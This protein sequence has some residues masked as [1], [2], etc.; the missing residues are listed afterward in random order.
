MSR[1]RF[2]G[3]MG[4][5]LVIPRVLEASAGRSSVWT[6]QAPPSEAVP[7]LL[8]TVPLGK[9]LLVKGARVV[10]K[11]NISWPNPAAWATTTSPDVLAAVVKHCLDRGASSVVV[12]DNPLGNSARCLERTGASGAIQGM[13]NT[14]LVM[15]TRPRDF[16]RRDLPDGS[17]LSQV[18]VSRELLPAT[19]IINLPKAKAHSATAVSFGMKNLMGLILDRQVFHQGADLHRAIAELLHVVRPHITL[20][21]ATTM[22][23]S[24]GPQGPGS[25][26]SPGILAA[27][28][29]PVAMDSYACSLARWDGRGVVAGDIAHITH[30]AAL[31]FGTVQFEVVTV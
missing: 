17:Q 20:L 30:A 22:L 26:L 21:D 28:E 13:Q 9:T 2:M 8:D 3:A 15:P 27:A 5:A 24:R 18:D 23:T 31:G 16:V 6:S 25:I 14:R 19:C 7:R 29:D 11:P 4:G 10:V 1:R 12:V